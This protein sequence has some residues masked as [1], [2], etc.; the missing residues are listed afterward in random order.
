MKKLIKRWLEPEIRRELFETQGARDWKKDCKHAF[1]DSTGKAYYRYM[2]EMNV[3]IQRMEKTEM[4][5]REMN[6]RISDLDIENYIEN[7]NDQIYKDGRTC[8][9]KLATIAELNAALK[10]RSE[11]FVDPDLMLRLI[12]CLYIREDQDPA[13]WDD[14]LEE[15]K[16]NRLKA[17]KSGGLAAFF[18]QAGLSTFLPS[19][20]QLTEESIK[21][22]EQTAKKF[23]EMNVK[24]KEAEATE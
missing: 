12:C 7:V 2:N 16:F 9:Q 17:D 3:P 15:E 20:K 13:V 5:L 23:R 18:Y 21:L 14:E 10:A 11:S 8:K 19:A 24:I 6:S 4:I 22:A 1:I